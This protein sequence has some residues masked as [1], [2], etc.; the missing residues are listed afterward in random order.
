M[1][2][3]ESV[4]L[5]QNLLYRKKKDKILGVWSLSCIEMR[6]L[7]WTKFQNATKFV[8]NYAIKQHKIKRRNV[9][10]FAIN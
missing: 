9:E 5:H 2:C 3:M 7:G 10:W 1:V 8:N 4:E 6:K